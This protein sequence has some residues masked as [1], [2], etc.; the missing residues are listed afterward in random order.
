MENVFT[1]KC[2]DIDYEGN[3]VCK[4]D[5]FPVFVPGC[6]TDELVRFEIVKKNK[7][8]AN[9]KL[10][11]ILEPSPFRAVPKCSNYEKCGGCSLMNL[12]YSKQLEYKKHI[13]S[14]TLKRIGKIDTF[15]SDCIGMDNPYYYR[16]NVQ[17]PFSYN[18]KIIAGFYESKTHNVVDSSECF[19][20]NQLVKKMI[21]YIKQLFIRYRITI[22]NESNKKGSIKHVV[23]RNNMKQDFM[24]IFVTKTPYLNH[25]KEICEDLIKRFKN[26]KSIV[27]N[28]NEEDTSVVLGRSNRIIYGDGIILDVLEGNSFEIGP[29]TFYQVNSMQ[30]KKLYNKAISYANI[31]SDDVIIDAYCGIGTI[32]LL[33][34][35]QAKKVYGIEIVKESIE[36]ANKNKI[37]N[38]V[39]NVEFYCGPA[40]K[41]IYDIIKKDHIDALIVDPPRKG[42]ELSF[43]DCVLNSNI[44]RIVYVSCNVRTL[45]RDLNYLSK[46]YDVIEVTPVD[47]FPHTVHVECVTLLS[48]KDIYD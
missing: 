37:A 48:L 9:G 19:I 14:D 36:N 45:S 38:N 23:F 24:V 25:E 22:Y 43:L 44:K 1:S 20:S 31:S 40:E 16:N 8:F 3:G 46:K 29:N 41:L 26:V 15:V 21:D 5:G 28:I 27:H 30:M 35:K 4:I 11:E 18:G 13:V 17:V 47:M 32:S 6:L 10:L 12:E 33:A 42:C 34:A 39:S 2:I 7:N